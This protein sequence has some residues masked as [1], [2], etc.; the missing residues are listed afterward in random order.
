MWAQVCLSTA[1][2]CKFEEA[3]VETGAEDAIL[4]HFSY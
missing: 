2:P 4:R 3:L 1:H